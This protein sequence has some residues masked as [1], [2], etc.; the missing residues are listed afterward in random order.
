MKIEADKVKMVLPWIMGFLAV[1]A[2]LFVGK[3]NQRRKDRK[4]MWP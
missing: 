4:N 1:F 3:K 2:G